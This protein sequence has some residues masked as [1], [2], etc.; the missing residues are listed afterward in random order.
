MAE[1]VDTP[2]GNPALGRSR[3]KTTD[4]RGQADCITRDVKLDEEAKK[5]GRGIEMQVCMRTQLGIGP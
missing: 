3:R 5:G 1:F 4:T 2:Q